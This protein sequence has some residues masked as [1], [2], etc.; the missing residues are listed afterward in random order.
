MTPDSVSLSD[1]NSF[2]EL[3]V[4]F[5]F[6]YAGLKG[7]KE[8]INR[9][10]LRDYQMEYESRLNQVSS[11]I[12]T[13][14]GGKALAELEELN[15]SETEEALA[16]ANI[17]RICTGFYDG[18]Y[19]Q[20]MFFLVG[21]EY[22]YFLILGGF[23]PHI[24][25][26]AVFGAVYLIAMSTIVYYIYVFLMLRRHVK[27]ERSLEN[28]PWLRSLSVLT[29]AG[30]LCVILTIFSWGFAHYCELYRPHLFNDYV[31][32]ED[33]FLGFWRNE[34]CEAGGVFLALSISFFP[35]NLYL[36]RVKL[37]I[38]PLEHSYRI[39]AEAGKQKLDEIMRLI[40]QRDKLNVIKIPEQ[41]PE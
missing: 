11:A 24:G 33:T 18:T 25:T 2:F 36:Y 7:F 1:F 35:Y 12:L 27:S 10:S 28:K 30:A 32:W 34:M 29:V 37:F 15:F 17:E 23:Q 31:V 3:M 26:M 9:V 13:V 6:A 21:L 8:Y 19:L 16:L 22:L 14:T 5:T 38:S 41:R 40:E 39:K 20:P 4:A